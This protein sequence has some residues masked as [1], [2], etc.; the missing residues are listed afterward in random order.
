MPITDLPNHTLE[1]FYHQVRCL[2]DCIW[3]AKSYVCRET[4]N[5]GDLVYVNEQFER[6]RGYLLG[7]K[8]TAI[9]QGVV[10]AQEYLARLE[11]GEQP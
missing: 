6:A 3:R 10:A 7:A 2:E 9:A 5:R 4:W 8:A 11:R 1:Q